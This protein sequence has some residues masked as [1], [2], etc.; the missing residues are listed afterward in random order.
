MLP[1]KKIDTLIENCRLFE[2]DHDPDGW[3]AIQMQ[4][5][6]NLCSAVEQTNLAIDLLQD[7]LEKGAEIKRQNGQWWI[8]NANGDGITC[9]DTVRQLSINILAT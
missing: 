2:I 9:G 1:V 3:P 8:F 6:S 4:D 5:I 7:Q